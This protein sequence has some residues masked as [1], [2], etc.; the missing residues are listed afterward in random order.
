MSG[1]DSGMMVC[2]DDLKFAYHVEAQ[3]IFSLCKQYNRIVMPFIRYAF[4]IST[5]VT[6]NFYVYL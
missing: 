3:F 1:S 2:F 6:P 5:A 4:Y